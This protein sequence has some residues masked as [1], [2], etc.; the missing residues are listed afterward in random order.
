MVDQNADFKIEN[1][2]QTASD[3]VFASPCEPLIPM[4]CFTPLRALDR[5]VSFTEVSLDQVFQCGPSSTPSL[6]IRLS[7]RCHS[8]PCQVYCGPGLLWSLRFSAW[9]I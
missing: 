2:T 1:L 8:S 9:F 6:K 5:S 7:V 4:E 3:A